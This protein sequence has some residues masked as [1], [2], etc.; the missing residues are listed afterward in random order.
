M[1]DHDLRRFIDENLQP[2]EQFTRECNQKVD[3]LAEFL[4]NRTKY[5]VS[6]VLKV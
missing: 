3:M 1:N 4:K 6:E 5:S 2:T